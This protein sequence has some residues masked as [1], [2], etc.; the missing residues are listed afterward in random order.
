MDGKCSFTIVLSAACIQCLQMESLIYYY[1]E[2]FPR[3][4]FGIVL[5]HSND[6]FYNDDSR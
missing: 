1:C 3:F 6:I 2:V 4:L 5:Y